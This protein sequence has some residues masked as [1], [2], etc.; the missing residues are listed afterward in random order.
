MSDQLILFKIRINFDGNPLKISYVLLRFRWLVNSRLTIGCKEKL[1]VITHLNIPFLQ[2]ALL[3]CTCDK[4]RMN[5][6]LF[7]CIRGFIIL[8]GECLSE[9]QSSS[10]HPQHVTSEYLPDTATISFTISG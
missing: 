4:V 3:L 9:M 2:T 7:L 6:I 5:H 10:L 8:T 1:L